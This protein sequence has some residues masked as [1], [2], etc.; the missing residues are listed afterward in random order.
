MVCC[1]TAPSHLSHRWFIITKVPWHS[2]VNIVMKRYLKTPIS[3]PRLEIAFTTHRMED[4]WLIN[5]K[6]LNHGRYCIYIYSWSSYIFTNLYVGVT[7]LR[8]ICTSSVFKHHQCKSMPPEQRANSINWINAALL[9]DNVHKLSCLWNLD[10][11]I[12][13]LQKMR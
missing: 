5:A 12:W 7:I 11:C 8:M 4:E 10:G 3:K 6:I 9:N 13:Y 2:S 1:V